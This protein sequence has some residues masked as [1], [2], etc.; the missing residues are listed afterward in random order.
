MTGRQPR[1]SKEEHAR[2]GRELYDQQVRP[3]VEA[4][5]HGKIVAIDIETGACELADDGLTASQRLLARMPDAQIWCELIGYP[6]VHHFTGLTED[7]LTERARS[8]SR[9]RFLRAMSKVADVDPEEQDK[10]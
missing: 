1:Y 3:E 5:N 6:A 7:Y 8:G 4:G 10:L 9:E 2:R